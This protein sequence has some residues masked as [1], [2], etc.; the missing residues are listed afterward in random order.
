[1][2]AQRGQ[3]KLY[4]RSTAGHWSLV[5]SNQPLATC[6]WSSFSNSFKIQPLNHCLSSKKMLT[7]SL[8][9]ARHYSRPWNTSEPQKTKVSAPYLLNRD[10]DDEQVKS[11]K[12]LPFG[13]WP[14]CRNSEKLEAGE[15]VHVQGVFRLWIR[16]R[17]PEKA[18]LPKD[19]GAQGALKVWGT[20]FTSGGA[21]A[22]ALRPVVLSFFSQLVM[23]DSLRPHGL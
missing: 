21:C 19:R 12:C 11:V 3:V 23:T 20:S 16:E 15:M 6:R 17:L 9:N 5:T 13:K 4:S 1:M 8:L 14:M 10:T 22:K 18:T 2:K 7:D